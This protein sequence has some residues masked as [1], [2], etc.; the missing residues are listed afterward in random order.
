MLKA[1]KRA[2]LIAIKNSKKGILT[3]NLEKVE[4]EG[5]EEKELQFLWMLINSDGT[6]KKKVSESVLGGVWN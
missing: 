1:I 3:L 6:M 4:Y 2:S 5:S